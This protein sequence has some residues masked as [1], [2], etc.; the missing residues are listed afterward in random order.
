MFTKGGDRT[1]ATSKMEPFVIIVN[2]WKLITSNGC[3]KT[4]DID[5]FFSNLRFIHKI[6]MKRKL[7]KRS[8][9]SINLPFKRIQNTV[10]HSKME[11]I[12]KMINS[13]KP[14]T[15]FAKTLNLR[16]LIMSQKRENIKIS[17]P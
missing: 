11:R 17:Y 6:E 8:N 14:L 7:A 1:V 2:G 3:S 16:F 13:C 15:I 5:K 12:A 9:I 10:K 4:I